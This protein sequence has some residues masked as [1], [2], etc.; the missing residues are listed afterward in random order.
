N[1]L[2]VCSCHRG[3]KAFEYRKGSIHSNCLP[4]LGILIR[5]V[6]Y[7]NIWHSYCNKQA[8]PDSFNDGCVKIKVEIKKKVKGFKYRKRIEILITGWILC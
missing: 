6:L 1:A 7:I 4:W 8:C 3:L 2:N 5:A